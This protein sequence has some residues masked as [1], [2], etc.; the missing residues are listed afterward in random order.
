MVFFF[1]TTH[2]SS[3]PHHQ[4]VLTNCS[5]KHSQVPLCIG[6]NPP[7]ITMIDLRQ[8]LFQFLFIYRS[9]LLCLIHQYLLTLD[10]VRFR[11]LMFSLFSS[12]VS[13]WPRYKHIYV[14]VIL[15]YPKGLSTCFCISFGSLVL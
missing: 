3:T 2:Q 7:L 12:C 15:S 6:S 1:L 13:Y 10:M 9:I 5:S 4:D 11:V 14:S 8:S